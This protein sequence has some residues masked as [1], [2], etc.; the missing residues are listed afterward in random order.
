MARITF[1]LADGL[2][3]FSIQNPLL[4]G[5]VRGVAGATV[6]IRHRIIHVLFSKGGLVGLVT[7]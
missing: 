2:M 5:L 6:G 4:V 1:V 3:G 7:V